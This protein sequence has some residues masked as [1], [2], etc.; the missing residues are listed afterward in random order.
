M[1][2]KI[3]CAREN[4]CRGGSP[5]PAGRSH[6]LSPAMRS[7]RTLA[8]ALLEFVAHAD[9]GIHVGGMNVAV[10][11]SILDAGVHN[12]GIGIEAF[13]QAIVRIKR[14]SFQRAAAGPGN[15]GGAPGGGPDA[16]TVLMIAI[17]GSHQIERLSERI[18]DAGPI[19][20]KYLVGGKGGVVDEGEFVTADVVEA[21]RERRG[22]IGK[23]NVLVSCENLRRAEIVQAHDA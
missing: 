17:V 6:G 4:A 21:R 16:V 9:S 7:L 13:A 3:T 18:P 20:L 1:N 19:H 14:E 22:G 12:A 5:R 15:A 2:I 10:G 23:T 11:E 8:A